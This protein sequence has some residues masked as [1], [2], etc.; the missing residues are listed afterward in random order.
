MKGMLTPILQETVNFVNALVIS[1]ERGI[2]IVETKTAEVQDFANLISVEVETDK[3]KNSLIG[4]L[5][6]K[7]DPRIVKINDYYVDCVPEGH[8]LVISNKDVP[9]IIGQI[10][11]ILGKNNINIAGMSFGRD[12][13]GGTAI[14][15]LNVDSDVPRGVLDEIRKAKNIQDVKLV[16]L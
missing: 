9:G 6:T 1:K 15:V 7:V 2:N 10:G 16:K 3:M 4:T 11:T 14:S 5:F 13:K 8:M 12:E